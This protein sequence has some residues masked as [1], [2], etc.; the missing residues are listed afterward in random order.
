MPLQKDFDLSVGA[1]PGDTVFK[2]GMIIQSYLNQLPELVV[3]ADKG[4]NDNDLLMMQ[5]ENFL[6]GSS[7]FIPV[8]SD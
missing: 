3:P 6:I 2:Y 7:M 5:A 4:C 1:H 8:F